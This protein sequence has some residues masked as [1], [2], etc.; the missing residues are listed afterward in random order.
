V[1]DPGG[2]GGAPDPRDD[3]IAIRRDPHAHVHDMTDGAGTADRDDDGRLVGLE[4][5]QRGEVAA[6]EPAGLIGDGVEHGR[7]RGAGGDE[8]GHA[9]QR[10]LLVGE[11]LRVG[12]LAGHAANHRT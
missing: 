11:E 8:L 12:E 1:L 6:E 7:L 9:P 10:R 5:Q 3:A 2:P 4:A